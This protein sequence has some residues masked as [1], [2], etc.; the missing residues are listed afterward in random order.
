MLNHYVKNFED[1]ELVR[2]R[3]TPLKNENYFLGQIKK[4]SDW[5]SYLPNS[6]SSGGNR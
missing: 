1:K 2:N 3:K 6:F 5:I 4:V